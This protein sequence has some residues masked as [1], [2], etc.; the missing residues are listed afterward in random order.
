[1]AE[2]HT[3]RDFIQNI[4][5]AGIG[6]LGFGAFVQSCAEK[7]VF[8]SSNL[9][10]LYIDGVRNIIGIIT[11]RELPKI[12]LAAGLAVQAKLQGH[13]LY[14]H[15]SDGMLGGETA[16]S[17]PGNPDVFITD[18]LNRARRDD[19]VVTDD[20]GIVRGFSERLVKVVGFTTP[21]IYNTQTPPGALENMGTFRIEDVS[22]IVIY[23][24]VPYTDGIVNVKGIDIPLFPASGIIHSI[25]YYALVSEIVENLAGYGV[26]YEIG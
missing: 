12:K 4:S 16:K 14:A 21:A 19:L 6:M 18:E 17:R 5:L 24:H 7:K 26:Y 15:F 2:Q 20:P 23:C 1:M 10:K 25:L 22:D 9:A 3:R 11:E 13:N 8:Y